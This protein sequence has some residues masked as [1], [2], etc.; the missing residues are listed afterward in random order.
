LIAPSPAIN[1]QSLRV[2]FEVLTAVSTKMA[3]FCVIVPCSL[4]EV[5]QLFR[6]P[7]CLRHQGDDAYI[8]NHRLD[9]I[10]S[11]FYQ[12]TRRYNPKDS[13]LPNLFGLSVKIHLK[14]AQNS[15]NFTLSKATL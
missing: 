13:H 9:K 8:L 14:T 1:K 5:Y 2:G 11:Y 3:V 7:Y 10:K 4:V 15:E 6:G 12:T